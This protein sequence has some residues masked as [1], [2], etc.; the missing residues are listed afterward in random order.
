MF[1]WQTG[2]AA[3][4]TGKLGLL[5]FNSI[6]P[7]LQSTRFQALNRGP[8]EISQLTKGAAL[9]ANYKLYY[10]YVAEYEL[11]TAQSSESSTADRRWSCYRYQYPHL[12]L[13][14]PVV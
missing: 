9:V 1:R 12:Y 14:P 8:G 11:S 4:Q 3:N 7:R 2:N 5:R 10:I 6:D 13:R